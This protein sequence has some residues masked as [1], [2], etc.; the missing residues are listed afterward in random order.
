M[1]GAV[2]TSWQ[3]C[4]SLPD[5][6]WILRHFAAALSSCPGTS[7]HDLLLPLPRKHILGHGR[8]GRENDSAN[9][10][11]EERRDQELEGTI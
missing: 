1:I 6:Y 8:E 5:N 4:C 7:G 9:S 11:S 2:T 10:G 3:G